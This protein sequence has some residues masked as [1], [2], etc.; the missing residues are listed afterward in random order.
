[1]RH[2]EDYPV[3]FLFARETLGLASFEK[4]TGIVRPRPDH[5]P[6]WLAKIFG[7]TLYEKS[8]YQK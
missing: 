4:A 7:G 3:T 8:T 6:K 1:M 2:F 5:R